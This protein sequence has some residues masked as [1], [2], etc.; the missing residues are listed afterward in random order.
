MSF[1]L[2]AH[3]VH[4]GANEADA[5]TN[6]GY[7]AAHAARSGGHELYPGAHDLHSGANDGYAAAH[8]G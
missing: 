2:C 6:D 8:A 1:T 5:A 4:S 3:G 7:A